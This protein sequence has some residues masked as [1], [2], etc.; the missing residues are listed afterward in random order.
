MISLELNLGS[1]KV[2]N[3]DYNAGDIEYILEPYLE[4]IADET[5]K[6]YSRR[7]I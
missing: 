4:Q 5:V 7:A 1:V 6:Y 3:G 2:S